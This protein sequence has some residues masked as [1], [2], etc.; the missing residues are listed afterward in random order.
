MCGDKGK[1]FKVYDVSYEFNDHGYVIFFK[2]CQKQSHVH[3]W[4]IFK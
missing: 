2:S 3:M 1:Q 4:I